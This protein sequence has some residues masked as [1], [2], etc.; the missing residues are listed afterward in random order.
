MDHSA[1]HDI[2]PTFYRSPA[3]AISAPPE[4]LAYVVAFDREAQQPDALAVLDTDPA[5]AGY[6]QV[7][8]W[9]DLP[10]RGDE[11]HHFG[12]NACSS[13]FAHAGHHTDGLQR[14]YL[15]LPGIR[16]S[17]IHVYD[18]H[19]D[20]RQPTLVRTISSDE[21]AEKAPATPART[22]CTAARTGSSCP[23]SAARA[24]RTGPGGIALL[25]HDTFDVLR[26]W[27]TDRGTAIPGLRRLVAPEPEHADHQ[28]VGHPVD[29]RGRDQPRTAARPQVR[30]PRCT[31][32]TWRRASTCR[33]STSA[34]S[35]RWCLSCGPSH[36]P[37]RDLG[38]RRRGGQH[39]RPV[40][41][42]VAVEPPGRQAGRA[43][44]VITIPAEPADPDSLPPALKPFGA[45]PPLVSDIDLS[46]DD[47]FLYVSCWGTGELKQYDVCDPAAPARSARSGSAAS[48][49]ASR[50]PPAPGEPLAGGPQMVEVSRD[51]K[52]I[53]LTN[54]LY[55]AW[56][57]QFYPDGVGA[58]MAKVDTDP[59]AAA[60]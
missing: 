39:R 15:L 4:Q 40:R 23:A 55:G 28:R 16:S 42:G 24:A 50:T 1:G 33:R 10:T 31:S 54:S 6:G 51:G 45:V 49:A 29:D 27:E 25:D 38:L 37:G 47:Q 3:D 57:D 22:P 7:V 12:W 34:S 36:D 5:S 18:T 60:G 53:Y 13:S 43:D 11:L 30:A 59:I 26:A 21:L 35:T 20:P 32:G 56:D 17:N 58:W 19:P 46:V 9:A 2:D 14:R 41:L 8:G 44:K 48:P 52:R